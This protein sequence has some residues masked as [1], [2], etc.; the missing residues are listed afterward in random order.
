M[1]QLHAAAAAGHVPTI[2]LLLERL[3]EQDA[4]EEGG[5]DGSVES[6]ARVG[7]LG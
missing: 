1:A 3:R 7:R 2:G 6:V 5:D 4:L